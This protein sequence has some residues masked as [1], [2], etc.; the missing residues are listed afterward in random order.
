MSA[1]PVA[2]KSIKNYQKDIWWPGGKGFALAVGVRSGAIEPSEVG[3]GKK[4]KKKKK[5]NQNEP[6]SLDNW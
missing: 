1:L 3:R 4:K 6:H 5:K 2:P